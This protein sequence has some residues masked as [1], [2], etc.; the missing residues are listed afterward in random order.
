MSRLRLS[1]SGKFIES[2]QAISAFV[3]GSIGP[4][5]S[6]FVVPVPGAFVGQLAFWAPLVPLPTGLVAAQAVVTAPGQVT[7]EVNN[8]TAGA[9]VV[10]ATDIAVQLT[11]I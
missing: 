3:F 4:G 1:P 7:I 9:I 2:T 10:P 8:T 6:N 11:T 5:V